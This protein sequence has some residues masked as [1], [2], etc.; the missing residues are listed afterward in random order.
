MGLGVGSCGGLAFSLLVVTAWL[1]T[2]LEESET[3]NTSGRECGCCRLGL[4]GLF[5]IMS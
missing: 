4:V 1:G 3:G 5:G 2:A